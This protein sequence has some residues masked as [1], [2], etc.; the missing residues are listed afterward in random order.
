MSVTLN[1]NGSGNGTNEDA[2]DAA[3][4]GSNSSNNNNS[5]N[6]NKNNKPCACPKSTSGSNRD[7]VNEP[8]PDG[9]PAKCAVCSRTGAQ[10]QDFFK[11]KWAGKLARARTSKTAAKYARIIAWWSK[12]GR[13]KLHADHIYPA[14][15][16]KKKKGFQQIESTNVDTARDIMTDQDNMQGLCTQ[17]NCLKGAGSKVKVGDI[18]GAHTEWLSKGEDHINRLISAALR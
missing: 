7:K 8:N 16:I 15:K 11:N 3:T 12:P 10:V 18:R 17:C 5:N 14:S 1:G 6:N 2:N 4:G 9:S 13:D